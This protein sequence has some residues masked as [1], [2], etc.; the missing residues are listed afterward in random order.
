MQNQ[1]KNNLNEVID[2]ITK[3]KS[4]ALLSHIGPDGDGIGSIL[5]L[6][7]A[8]QSLDKNVFAIASGG[9]PSN[10][11]FLSGAKSFQQ[12]INLDKVDCIITLDVSNETRLDLYQEKYTEKMICIDH[13]PGNTN[14]ASYNYID[15]KVSSTAEM[16]GNLIIELKINFSKKISEAILTGILFDTGN[17]TH[18]FYPST[19][20]ILGKCVESGAKINFIKQKLHS[21]KDVQV[22]NLWGFALSKLVILDKNKMIY[23]V[24][25]KNDLSKIKVPY[26]DLNLDQL[27]NLLSCIDE[28]NSSL[29]LT[30]IKEKQYKASLRSENF[31]NVNVSSIAKKFGGGGHIR[32][33]GFKYKGEI[34]DLLNEI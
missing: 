9:I 33:S 6:K 2:F 16:V 32:A 31:K 30:E 7:F 14:F 17:L 34:D 27:S 21:I 29:L 10:Y 11:Y 28:G 12:K 13:H 25:D 18:N 24:I 20:R 8:L 26:Q 5:A 1:N 3:S 23:S 15:L 22:L 19:L 4:I